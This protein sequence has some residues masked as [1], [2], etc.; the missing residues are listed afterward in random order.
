MRRIT[1]TRRAAADLDEIWLHAATESLAA[2]DR[3]IDRIAARCHELA[4]HPELG[5]ARPKIA[6]EARMLVINDYLVLYRIKASSVQIVRV[7]HGARRLQGL[8]DNS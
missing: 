2:A 1:R 5:P 7:V 3:L 8:F 6:P 4:E